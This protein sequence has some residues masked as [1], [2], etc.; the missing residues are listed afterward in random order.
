MA[1][2]SHLNGQI[3]PNVMSSLFTFTVNL[4]TSSFCLIKTFFTGPFR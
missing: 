4:G 2:S 3:Y 1:A